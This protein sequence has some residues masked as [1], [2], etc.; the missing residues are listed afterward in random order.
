MAVNTKVKAEARNLDRAAHSASTSHLVETL[1]RLGYG[2]R[3]MVYGVIGI[4][5]LQVALG[6]SGTLTDPQ[7]AI[8]AMGQ[9]PFGGVVLYVVL[10]GLIGYGLWGL[11]R[12][13][14]DP[15]HRGT[16]PKGIVVRLGYAVSGISYLLLALSTY[17]LLTGGAA[18]ARGGAQTAQTQQGTATILA[19]PGGVWVVVLAAAFIMAIGILQIYHGLHRKFDQQ[20]TAYELNASQRKWITRMGQFGT[21]ARGLVFALIGV[22]M[23]LAA[24]NHDPR[25]AQ[26]FDGVLVSLLHQPYGHILIGFIA[27]GLIAFG[28]Y[29]I[30]SGIWLRLKK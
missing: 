27:L 28:I 9:T 12:A 13:A 3:G 2:A 22:F 10:L 29:S 11:I 20:F 26:G 4:L 8:V 18:A 16:E 17:G 5:A 6:G 15:L 30:M 21:A 7:G 14:F 25:L 19:Q 24:Y 23:F 1:M